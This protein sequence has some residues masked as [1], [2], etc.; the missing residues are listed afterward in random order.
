MEE[1]K[2]A[3][4][5]KQSKKLPVIAIVGIGCIGL[6]VVTGII[7]SI[8]G[9]VLFSRFGAGLLKKG[10]ESKTGLS[11]NTDK[12]QLTFTDKDTGKSISV[13]GSQ[14]LPDTFPK[15]FPLYPGATVKGS[16]SGNDTATGFWIVMT[17]TDDLIKVTAFYKTNL[18]SRGWTISNTMTLDTTTTWGVTK[19][20]LE[21]SVMVLKNKEDKE[22]SINITLQDKTTDTSGSE[23][24]SQS[25]DQSVGL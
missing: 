21:G 9:K 6:L 14:E 25:E 24:P 23:A 19:G 8:A 10:I 17:S 20:N 7:L 22:T 1:I 5:P 18:P 3:D 15:D 11:I 12:E 13:G 2:T 16:M 4:S